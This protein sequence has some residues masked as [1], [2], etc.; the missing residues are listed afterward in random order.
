M[1]ALVDGV[2]A[3]PDS[4]AGCTAADHEE[5]AGRPREI[6]VIDCLQPEMVFAR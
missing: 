1:A 6:C 2:E 4:E 3:H 5:V